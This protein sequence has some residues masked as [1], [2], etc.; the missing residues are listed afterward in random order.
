MPSCRDWAAE[1]AGTLVGVAGPWPSSEQCPV[2]I[3][4]SGQGWHL[5][6]LTEARLQLLRVWWWKGWLV[7]CE[8]LLW[9][10]CW[11][12][13]RPSTWCGSAA[14]SWGG[15]PAPAKIPHQ[16]LWR[17]RSQ[18]GGTRARVGRFGPQ[19]SARVGH[20]V[21]ASRVHGEC[22]KRHLPVLG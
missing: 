19:R 6:W 8:E 10:Q 17:G 14:A 3:A 11:S 2:A 18:C 22:Q 4:T 12:Q 9:G 7:L 16:V 1:A 15:V 5:A 20:A 21:P 13:S